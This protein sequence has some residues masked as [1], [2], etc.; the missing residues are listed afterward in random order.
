MYGAVYGGK[1]IYEGKK[2]K[3]AISDKKN[4]EMI[5]KKKKTF[6]LSHIADF[7]SFLPLLTIFCETAPW[8]SA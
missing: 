2:E 5:M 8:I 1:K 6:F 4:S 7:F 3:L